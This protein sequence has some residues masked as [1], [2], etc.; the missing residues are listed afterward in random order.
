[1]SNRFYRLCF[2]AILLFSLYFDVNALLYVL[3]GVATFEAVTNLRIPKLVSR[4]RH[5]NDGD[6]IEG[7]LGIHFTQRTGFEAERGWRLTVAAVLAVSLFAY[8]DHL[9]FFPWFMGFAILGAGVS[10]VC[11]MFLLLKWAGLK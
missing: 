2:G 9:W 8:P 7:C 5:G 6:P 1:M 3:I 4:Q 11:P 10:G